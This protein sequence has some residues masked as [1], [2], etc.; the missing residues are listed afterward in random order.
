MNKK[1]F[2]WVGVLVS[3]V[4]FAADVA[5][6]AHPIPVEGKW[7]GTK[8]ENPV[9]YKFNGMSMN[10]RSNVS[11]EKGISVHLSNLPSTVEIICNYRNGSETA[12]LLYGG[13]AVVSVSEYK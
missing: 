9:D 2:L 8:I 12:E 3:S 5:C 11:A 13:E 7:L 6:P 1:L 4:S 10:S